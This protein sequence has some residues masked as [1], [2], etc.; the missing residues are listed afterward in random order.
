MVINII[1]CI[2]KNRAIGFN[3]QLLYHIK[4]DMD[5]FRAL[6]IGHTIVMGRKTF[7]SLP[8][9][10]LPQRRNIVISRSMKPTEEVEVYSSI[11]STLAHCHDEEAIFVIGGESIYT[12]FLPFTDKIFLTLVKD[13][14]Q[15]WDTLFPAINPQEWKRVS[16]ETHAFVEKATNREISYH[17]IELERMRK[18]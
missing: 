4:E 8:K 3:N 11:E 12:Q 13:I 16:K 6:T 2:A 17:F 1:A 5:R 14:P 18:E 15:N 9:G 10:A 7:E